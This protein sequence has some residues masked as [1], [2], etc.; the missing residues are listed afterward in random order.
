[1]LRP[2]WEPSTPAWKTL[3]S[4]L[5]CI[6]H[7]AL[8]ACYA[9]EA[10]AQT[11]T[12]YHHTIQLLHLEKLNTVISSM[13]RVLMNMGILVGIGSPSSARHGKQYQEHPRT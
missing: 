8:C 12:G 13:G 2:A 4:A 11:L 10:R 1:M 3:S 6:I 9:F 5:L 7:Q